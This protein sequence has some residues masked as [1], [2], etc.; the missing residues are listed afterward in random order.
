MGLL[1]TRVEYVGCDRPRV[2]ADDL[3]DTDCQRMRRRV[4]DGLWIEASHC[5]TCAERVRACKPMEWRVRDHNGHVITADF[6]L[7]A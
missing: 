5:P 4:R 1:M 2:S 6:I 7:A 3:R